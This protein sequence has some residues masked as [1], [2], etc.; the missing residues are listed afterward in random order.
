MEALYHQVCQ[1]IIK[2]GSADIENHKQAA[3]QLQTKVAS[4]EAKHSSA[5]L[6][7]ED[8]RKAASKSAAAKR[9]LERQV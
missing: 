4:T 1:L 7:L 5:L 3:Q 8:I 2:V 9:M 6:K